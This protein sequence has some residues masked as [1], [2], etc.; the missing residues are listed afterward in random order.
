MPLPAENPA[1]PARKDFTKLVVKDS[2]SAAAWMR[3]DGRLERK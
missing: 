1:A 2:P 3:E